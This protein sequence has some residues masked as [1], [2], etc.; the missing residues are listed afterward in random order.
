MTTHSYRFMWFDRY[1][2]PRESLLN[3]AGDVTQD[4]RYIT[5]YKVH[6]HTHHT[7]HGHTHTSHPHRTLVNDMVH[8][9]V[10]CRVDGWVSL[11]SVAL[12]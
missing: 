6:T 9:L 11:D 10:H 8:L 5:P 2:V 3:R 12:T 7:H 1:R 4:G